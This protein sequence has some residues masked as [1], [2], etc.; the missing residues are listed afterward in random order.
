MSLQTAFLKAV[1]SVFRRSRGA[2]LVEQS[3]LVT[4]VALVSFA[5]VLLVGDRTRCHLQNAANFLA[6]GIIGTCVPS[7]DPGSGGTP[8][9]AGVAETPPVL[10]TPEGDLPLAT[11]GLGYTFQFLA[12]DPEGRTLSFSLVAGD[13]PAG[14]VLSPVGTLQGIP[15]VGGRYPLIVRVAAPDGRDAVGSYVLDV[16]TPPV[17]A[18]VPMDQRRVPIGTSREIQIQATDPD[19]DAMTYAIASGPAWASIDPATGMLRLE[20]PSGTS[21]TADATITVVV[22][23]LRR[24][25]PWRTSPDG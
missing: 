11:V 13:L 9:E 2:T 23:D 15:Q 16:N 4:L 17:V 20:P 18:E 5:A 10:E 22:T 24:S 12:T 14:I 6:F 8:P 19:G 21:P 25:T 7:A 3:F 1:L